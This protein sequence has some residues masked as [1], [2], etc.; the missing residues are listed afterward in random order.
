METVTASTSAKPERQRADNGAGGAEPLA[1]RTACQD[2]DAEQDRK[3]DHRPETER[4]AEMRRPAVAPVFRCCANRPTPAQSRRRPWRRRQRRRQQRKQA[5]FSAPAMAQHAQRTRSRSRSQRRLPADAA[6]PSPAAARLALAAVTAV[7]DTRPP[8]AA[9]SSSPCRAPKIFHRDVAEEGDRREHDRDQPDFAR[10]DAAE[11]TDRIVRHHRQRDEGHGEQHQRRAQFR[12]GHAAGAGRAG[13]RAAP[14][15]RR[16]PR[17]L[18]RRR[19]NR[20][21][22][23]R[24]RARMSPSPQWRW[25]RRSSFRPDSRRG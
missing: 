2:D 12:P 1:Q 4:V 9:A 15:S 6:T 24:R 25:S 14:G 23:H 17:P 18:P 19:A 22:A 8:A 16:L 11:R 3:A 5:G 10:I 7:D 20:R 13:P 21:P